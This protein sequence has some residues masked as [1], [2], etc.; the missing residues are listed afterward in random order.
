MPT[1]SLDSSAWLSRPSTITRIFPLILSK[2]VSFPKANDLIWYHYFVCFCSYWNILPLPPLP[3]YVL[4]IHQKK[5]P[6]TAPIC[7]KTLKTLIF[8]LYLQSNYAK[9]AMFKLPSH[10][11]VS[12]GYMLLKAERWNLIWIGAD[13]KGYERNLQGLQEII[14]MYRFNQ[15]VIH[16]YAT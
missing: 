13:I 4:S 9:N 11:M 14:K 16:S 2:C 10:S 3:M 7:W 15:A 8:S 12:G 6:F 1:A 5:N